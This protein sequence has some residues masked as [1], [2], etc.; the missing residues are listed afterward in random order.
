MTDDE[1]G[2]RRDAWDARH[3][4]RDIESGDPDPTFVAEVA[5]LAA[6]RALEV[7][8]G[9]GTNA[10]WLAQNGWRV[11]AVDWSA[12]ALEKGRRRAA[13]VGVEIDWI[14][15]DLLAW[16]APAGAFELVAALYLHPLPNERHIIYSAIARAIAPGGHLLVIGHD[17]QNLGRGPG[18]PDPD[19]LF[20]AEDLGFELATALPQLE[21]EEARAVEHGPEPGQ[22]PVDA[23]LRMRRRPG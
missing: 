20:T 17:R 15:A 19:R 8:C 18:P 3:R 21:I 5:K 2:E 13:Q 4:E 1:R 14:E 6:G 9:S 23:L 7:A 22:G 10:V 12:V 11:T 16:Q